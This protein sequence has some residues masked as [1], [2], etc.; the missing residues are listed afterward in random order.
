MFLITEKPFSS[1]IIYIIT[2]WLLV[3]PYFHY[4]INPTTTPLEPNMLIY[5]YRHPTNTHHLVSS[6]KFIDL[7]K[8]LQLQVTKLHFFHMYCQGLSILSQLWELCTSCKNMGL[9]GCTNI[10]TVQKSVTNEV[11]TTKLVLGPFDTSIHSI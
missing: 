3:H 1:S 7:K 11:E 5:F 8:W 10:I 6:K 2:L 4:Q 9:D